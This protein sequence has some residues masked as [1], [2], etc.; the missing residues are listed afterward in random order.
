MSIYLVCICRNVWKKNLMV[1]LG[2]KLYLSFCVF[3]AW[4]EWMI[5]CVLKCAALS[6]LVSCRGRG[7]RRDRERAMATAA[8]F[9]GSSSP[10]TPAPATTPPAQ[11]QAAQLIVL[12]ASLHQV[13]HTL[14][15]HLAIDWLLSQ[16]A[17]R[18]R[19]IDFHLT[20]KWKLKWPFV[21]KSTHIL[22]C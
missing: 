20:Q 22:N 12:P 13:M 2:N 18:V 11:A 14:T 3:A 1:Y 9:V 5:F 7:I 8:R 15:F 21:S 17:S 4:I 16:P 6:W 10:P 19:T